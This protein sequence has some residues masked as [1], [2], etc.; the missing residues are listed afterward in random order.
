MKKILYIDC[1]SGISG[2]MMLGSLLD[3]GLD[4]NDLREELSK[5]SISGYEIDFK[6]EITNGIKCTNFKVIVTEDQPERSYI[7]IQEIINKSSLSNK[8]KSISLS[9]FDILA[10]AEAKIHNK[11]FEELHFHE[12]GAIDSIIDIVGTAIAIDLLEI[13]EVLCSQGIPLGR[14]FINTSHGK[15]PVPAPATLEILKGLPV[16]Y[17]N[18]DFEVTTPTGAAI[19]KSLVSCFCNLPLMNI[20]R[21]GYG[22]GSRVS[23]VSEIPNLLRVLIGEQDDFAVRKEIFVKV[24]DAGFGIENIVHLVTNLDDISS[25]IISYLFDKL[26]V[27]GALD[28]WTE[29]ILMKKNRQAITLNVLCYEKDEINLSKKIFLETSTLGIRRQKLQRFFLKRKDELIKLPYGEVKVKIGYLND[30]IV[31]YSPEYESCKKLA[32][33]TK[34]PLKQVYQDAIFFFSIK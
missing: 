2:D 19:L 20:L 3:C 1:F 21:I 26:L 15:I 12:I 34:K 7:Q 27:E 24:Q 33:K 9:I 4:F 29:P 23:N 14:G 16:Y 28:V 30:K 18:F 32:E 22:K 11:T 5:L 8:S 13:D 6:Q 10:Q 25:E 17:G 31:T